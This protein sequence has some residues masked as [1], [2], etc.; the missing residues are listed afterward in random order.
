M[1]ESLRESLFGAQRAP[2]PRFRLTLTNRVLLQEVHMQG[3]YCSVDWD[4]GT[5]DRCLFTGQQQVPQT[6]NPQPS[7]LKTFICCSTARDVA[8]HSHATMTEKLKDSEQKPPY[9][10]KP[11]YPHRSNSPLCLT[12]LR[13][14]F[15]HSPF[16]IDTQDYYLAKAPDAP[17]TSS[18]PVSL[19]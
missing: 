19:P 13:V 1:R 17:N 18:P 16:S 9:R 4:N 7:T 14:L 3:G 15:P 5:H 10:T 6:L 12:T 8:P 11:P 2:V